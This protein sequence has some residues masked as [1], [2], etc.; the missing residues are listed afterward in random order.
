MV[1]VHYALMNREFCV[2]DRFVPVAIAISLLAWSSVCCR[3]LLKF[4]VA[5][6]RLNTVNQV[7]RIPVKR[8]RQHGG[9]VGLRVKRRMNLEQSSDAKISLDSGRCASAKRRQSRL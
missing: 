4:N 5:R 1:S 9:G 2:D 8:L 6:A 3:S 7:K